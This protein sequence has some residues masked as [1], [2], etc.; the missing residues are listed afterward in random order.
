MAN[1]EVLTLEEACQ[2]TGISRNYMYKLTSMNKIPYAK[3]RGKS[4]Y[5]ERTKLNAWLLGN[6]KQ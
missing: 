5:F 3:P 6:L 4:I 2:Y 1:K